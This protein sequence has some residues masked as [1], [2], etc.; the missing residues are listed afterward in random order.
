M[1]DKHCTDADAIEQ[2]YLPLDN[3]QIAGIYIYIYIYT[4][5]GGLR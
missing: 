5:E 1:V 4:Q 2:G 3:I